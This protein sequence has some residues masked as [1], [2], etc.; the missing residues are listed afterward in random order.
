MFT[1]LP[2]PQIPNPPQRFI[3][4]AL[5]A[6]TNYG[7]FQNTALN[8]LDPK[9]KNRKLIKDG[10]RT[11]SRMQYG[12]DLGKDWQDWVCNNI[13]DDYISTGARVS[14]GEN[15]TTHGAHCDSWIEGKPCY[16]LYFLVDRGGDR[17]V[18]C[19]FREKGQPLER[20]GTLE[21]IVYVDD[22]DQLDVIDE[23][24]F[25]MQQW[26]LFNPNI[27]HGVENVTSARTNLV[28]IFNDASIKVLF[29]RSIK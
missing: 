5:R 4:Q 22:Y 28:V 14:A 23:V 1:W 13:M 15:T 7:D 9:Y 17:A 26:I 29:Q 20:Q 24:R 25:P 21:N 8:Q 27:L 6:A 19:F 16:K 11:N 3:D 2:Q 10:Q 18:T 12:I